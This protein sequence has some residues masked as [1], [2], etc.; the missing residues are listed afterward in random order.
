[1]GRFGSLTEIGRG[2]VNSRGREEIQQPKFSNLNLA[3]HETAC[4]S[5]SLHTGLQGSAIVSCSFLESA[6]RNGE[7]PTSTRGGSMKNFYFG[8]GGLLHGANDWGRRLFAHLGLLP[9]FAA[10][11]ILT[12]CPKNPAIQVSSTPNS[13]GGTLH[14]SG[15]GFTGGGHVNFSATNT[16]GHATIEPIG[17]TNAASDGS[18]KVDL[19]FSWP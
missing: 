6:P 7:P 2:E 10:L 19:P 3:A 1:M 11:L 12:A 13:V 18:I 14:I 8:T 4:A 9:V 17:G 16:P 5:M 15:Q